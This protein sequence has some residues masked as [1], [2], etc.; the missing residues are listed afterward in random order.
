MKA[1]VSSTTPNPAP[2]WPPVSET[3]S[4]ISWLTSFARIF[5]SD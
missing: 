3:A 1:T 5:S 2:R 4:I